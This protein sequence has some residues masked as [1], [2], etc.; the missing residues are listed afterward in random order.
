MLA[1]TP[2]HDVVCPLTV[3][4][5]T[6]AQLT[7]FRLDFAPAN[8]SKS[9]KVV[10]TGARDWKA[11]PDMKY[12]VRVGSCTSKDPRFHGIGYPQAPA[13]TALH[14]VN[15]E[16]AFPLVSSV[17]PIAV[18]PTGTL[19]TLSGSLF[20]PDARVFVAG[21][22][23]ADLDTYPFANAAQL[24][25][26]GRFSSRRRAP[27][28]WVWAKNAARNN[29]VQPILIRALEEMGANYTGDNVT[30]A[31]PV[32]N[33]TLCSIMAERNLSKRD[34]SFGAAIV[35]FDERPDRELSDLLDFRWL[36]TT[37]RDVFYAQFVTPC[38]P[39]AEVPIDLLRGAT[40]CSPTLHAHRLGAA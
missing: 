6:E 10:V 13:V 30:F 19:I 11:E 34:A 27:R 7:P 37:E 38:L 4:P 24:V 29:R 31:D 8:A 25:Q 35:D 21:Y 14:L 17:E 22:V 1:D 15:K 26:G 12:E 5:P 20:S 39:S 2:L 28:R 16:V 36:R 18:R 40:P 9:I 23:L 33:S 32:Y 3:D